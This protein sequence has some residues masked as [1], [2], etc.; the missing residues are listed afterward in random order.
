MTLRPYPDLLDLLENEPAVLPHADSVMIE[1]AVRACAKDH[2]EFGV[3]DVR[4]YYAWQPSRPNRIGVTFS[5]LVG[6]GV[7]VAIDGARS[8]NTKSRNGN[9]RVNLYRLGDT[10]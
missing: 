6:R 5:A 7:I 2:T 10:T 8:G 1:E 9:K 4:R 3:K